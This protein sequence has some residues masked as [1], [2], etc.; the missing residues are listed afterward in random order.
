MRYLPSRKYLGNFTVI[1][2][3]LALV[4][5]AAPIAAL[6]GPPATPLPAGDEYNATLTQYEIRSQLGLKE[7]VEVATDSDVSHIIALCHRIGAYLVR[8]D[9]G[10]L[11]LRLDNPGTV[12][13]SQSFLNDYQTG[14]EQINVLIKRGW[15]TV[16]ENL[17]LQPGPQLPHS[18]AAIDAG[19]DEIEGRGEG[20]QAALSPAEKPENSDHG[21]VFSLHSYRHH[22]PYYYASLG[23]TFA[24]FFHHGLYGARFALLFGLNQPFFHRTFHHGGYAFAPWHNPRH[25]GHKHRFFYWPNHYGYFTGHWQ[26]VFLYS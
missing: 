25:V 17:D 8:Q 20:T 18:Q 21:F 3:L 4:F 11:T 9:D 23:P 14:L 7:G 1:A 15:V 24:S 2:L 19:L 6:A 16:D 5:T 10:T 13:V 22:I 12:G 26:T